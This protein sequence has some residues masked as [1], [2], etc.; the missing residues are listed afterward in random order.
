ME[1]NY[2]FTEE[3]SSVNV[4]ICLLFFISGAGAAAAGSEL[5]CA[6]LLKWLKENFDMG[7]KCSPHKYSQ[8]FTSHLISWI[9][10]L[11]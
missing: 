9:G 11:G 5:N 6:N 1:S 3:K 8:Y 2:S 7:M 4:F 10:C